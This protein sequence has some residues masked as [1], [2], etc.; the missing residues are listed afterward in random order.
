MPLVK[1]LLS[2]AVLVRQSC[3]VFGISFRFL[4]ML[5]C[6]FTAVN[7]SQSQSIAE[8]HYDSVV[9]E[10]SSKILAA[11]PFS[12][13]HQKLQAQEILVQ[14]YKQLNNLQETI[15]SDS[16]RKSELKKLHAIFLKQLS[17]ALSESQIEQVKD[18]MTYR[19]FPITMAAYEDMLPS[20]TQEQKTQIY[21]WLKEARELAMDEGSSNKKHAMFGKY[22]GRINNYLSAQGY[23]MKKESK[24]WE[25]RLKLRKEQE[26]KNAIQ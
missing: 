6:F 25:E 23:D 20:L 14:Q 7:N 13:E 19:V 1:S 5:L 12:D 16:I 11:I 26:K 2:S 8:L 22:K 18:G 4:L 21:N 3:Q 24:E 15:Q 10:R 17:N 9:R